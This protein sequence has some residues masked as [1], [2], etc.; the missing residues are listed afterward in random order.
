MG[1]EFKYWAFISY[2]HADKKWGD[3]LHSALET[4][5]V[6]KALAGSESQPG[7]ALPR[8]IFPIFRDREELP[9]SS[10]L[11][12]MI[13]E[14]LKQ[15][16]CL[17][18]ICS[19]RSAKS[20]W[21][22]Q[23]IL[24]FKRLGRADRILALIVDGEP[25]AADGKPG[26]SVEAECFPEALKYALGADGHLDTNRQI[27]PIAADA[28]HGMDGRANAMLKVA[29]G[30]LG[31]N[32]DDLKR[33][34]ER[35]RRRQQRIVIAV[36]AA[37]VLTFAA[38]A[39][40]ALLQWRTATKETKIANAQTQ[41][42]ER[43]KT[44]ADA[45]RQ[46]AETQKTIAQEKT[47]EA[48][49]EKEQVETQTAADEEDLAREALLR[50]DPLTAAQ[51]VSVAFEAEP[52]DA[53]VRLLLHTAMSDLLGLAKVL[54]GGFGTFTNMQVSPVSGLVLTVT[55]DG[56]A[57]VWDPKKSAPVL[58]FGKSGNLYNQVH[59]AE[60]TPDGK[61]V[62]LDNNSEAYLQEIATGKKVSF[63]AG[64]G[65]GFAGLMV[66]SDGKTV[67]GSMLN[68]STDGKAFSTQIA[69][70]SSSDGHQ[71]AQAT[72]AGI[73]SIVAV[74]G[75]AGRAVLIGGPDATNPARR[76]LVVDVVT[77]KI[78]AQISVTWN[79]AA[80]VNP[81]GDLILINYASLTQPPG[82][83]SAQSGAKV[84]ELR[85][86][87]VTAT[88]ASWSPSGR[89][90][91]SAYPISGGSNEA[92]WDASTW[93]P[94][95]VWPNAVW[96]ATAIDPEESH[97]AS[98][99]GQGEFAV[100]D[101]HSGALLRQFDDDICAGDLGGAPST[102]FSHMQFSPDGTRL[103]NAGGG[104]CATIWNWQ[105][106]RSSQL[107]YSGSGAT[108]N[109]IAFSP[110]GSRAVLAGNDGKAVV[111]NVV[112]GAA[113][114]TLQ[115]KTT[116]SGAAVNMAFFTP[117]GK[118]VVTGGMFLEAALWNAGNGSLL[119][120]L[121][122]DKHAIVAGDAISVAMVRPGNRAVTFSSDGWGALWDLAAQ[123]QLATLH[124]EDGATVRKVSPAP[125]GREFVVIDTGAFAFVFDSLSG[126]LKRKLGKPGTPLAAAEISPQGDKLLTA[127][128]MG[129][130]TI[131]SLADGRA[132][133]TIN[134]AAGAAAVN[135]V[136]FSP[137]GSTILAAC[138]DGKAR[139]W[140]AQTGQPEL[141]IA[142]ETVPGEMPGMGAP[143][144]SDLASGTPIQAGMLRVEYSPDGSFIA[145]ANQGINV[146]VWDAKT[147]K[148]LLRLE[149]HTGRIASL[150]F[151]SDG[152]R[153]GS[154]SEDGT[155]RIW[156]LG[157]ENRS[158]AEIKQEIAEF[159]QKSSR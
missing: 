21:V 99:A 80:L 123:K 47:V 5:K 70:Y 49:N 64:T 28:R 9:T 84:A 146:L 23:E 158:P 85:T 19:P 129:K 18:V 103:I 13:A 65:Q 17:I 73:Y 128:A 88:H 42:A 51:I 148:Q 86:N 130:I 108:I 115:S 56:E 38:L 150:A 116:Q 12:S 111:W 152:T 76:V 101:L 131:W 141:T 145:G 136:H 156:D 143:F 32:Y 7:E 90:V 100:W 117:D 71:T 14:A 4:Y 102:L 35:R 89:Y 48:Q 114:F 87:D 31:I 82:I 107:V 24:E 125:D 10:D 52:Q 120:I 97:V 109:N 133:Q 61:G 110:D 139:T 66:S 135:D 44:E 153:L 37:L 77:G 27:E 25:N 95:H 144:R 46:A 106:V 43:Q 45:Q 122:F 92:L 126:A 54:N 69:T 34:E 140:N 137:D 159:G 147:G 104:A 16:R 8:K 98:V 91:L 149:G 36:S 6:P 15:S 62:L 127:D 83:Y 2:S 11:G 74:P 50:G 119:R 157:L 96:S 93:K 78:V 132:L 29:A 3:W 94:I 75:S 58:I 33:R 67:M 79:D 124:T 118:E 59:T 41:E 151:S 134:G 68:I 154:T 81:R 113:Q 112:T 39:A 72:V 40:A 30:I 142:E 26:F 1:T 121:N 53:A 138:T 20:R 155:A 105:Q 57:Q 55:S 22:N 60:F 63:S